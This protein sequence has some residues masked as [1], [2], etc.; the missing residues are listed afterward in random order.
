MP[1]PKMPDVCCVRT[2]WLWVARG[3]FLS[4]CLARQ[5]ED[6]GR[7]G[8]RKIRRELIVF[9]NVLTMLLLYM[10]NH[11]ILSRCSAVDSFGISVLPKPFPFQQ[12]LRHNTCVEMGKKCDIEK[13]ELA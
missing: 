12:I 5:H 4:P 8:H 2:R 6:G 11:L 1:H 7:R 3:S 9:E 13:S 10:T